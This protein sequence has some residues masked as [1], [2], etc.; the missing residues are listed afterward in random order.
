MNPTGPNEDFQTAEV[1]KYAEAIYGA[2]EDK[3]IQAISD[4]L[5][6]GDDKDSEGNPIKMTFEYAYA[7]L[8]ASGYSLSHRF[9]ENGGTCTLEVR[10]YKLASTLTFDVKTAYSATIA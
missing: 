6:L 10:I 4:T 3:L 1:R 7:K 9:I 5:G 2:T 8:I